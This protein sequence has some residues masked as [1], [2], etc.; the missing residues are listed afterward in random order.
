MQNNL[1]NELSDRLVT[2]ITNLYH[3][4][5]L[6]M[7]DFRQG[8]IDELPQLKTLMLL[9]DKGP[10]RVGQIAENT[11]STPSAMTATLHRLVDRNL[12]TRERYPQDRRVVICELTSTGRTVLNGIKHAIRE[13]VLA[14]TDTWSMEQFEAVVKALESMHPHHL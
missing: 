8:P 9:A 6:G 10:L 13:R 3:K 7:L 2:E 12:V 5:Y 14:A 1:R 4:V 11:E